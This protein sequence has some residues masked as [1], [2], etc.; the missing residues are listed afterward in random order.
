[1]VS[2]PA[3][4]CT[5]DHNSAHRRP[6][7]NA[8]P[9]TCVRLQERPRTLAM[10]KVVGSSPIIRLSKPAAAGGFSCSGGRRRKLLWCC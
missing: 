10:Q 5:M 9:R 7:R 8:P 1:M 6:R 2:S 3:H 4:P